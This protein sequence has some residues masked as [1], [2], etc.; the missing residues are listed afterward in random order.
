MTLTSDDTSKAVGVSPLPSQT[1][2]LLRQP[3]Q[4]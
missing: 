3:E 2:K 4:D 1:F